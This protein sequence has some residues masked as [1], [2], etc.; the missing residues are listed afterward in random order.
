VI[1]CAEV[2]DVEEA[3]TSSDKRGV[4]AVYRPGQPPNVVLKAK[5]TEEAWDDLLASA[6]HLF[7]TFDWHRSVAIGYLN[8]SAKERR[9]VD[10]CVHRASH[11]AFYLVH[12][13]MYDLT[14]PARELPLDWFDR[15]VR[16]YITRVHQRRHAPYHSTNWE[17]D[18]PI[19]LGR[20]EAARLTAV[21]GTSAPVQRRGRL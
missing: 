9:L 8:C 21:M 13:W 18:L 1:G 16:A 2:S 11:E 10:A 17:R 5:S 6:R 15:Y 14:P 12:R 19:A 3:L 20:V 7:H 4:F